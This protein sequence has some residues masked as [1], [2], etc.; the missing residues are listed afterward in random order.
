MSKP[1]LPTLFNPLEC[2]PDSYQGWYQ[3]GNGLWE[4]GRF[5][6]ALMSFD[7][8]IDYYPEDY[9]AWYKRGMTLEQLGRFTEA[10]ESYERAARIQ[11]N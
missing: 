1:S 4:Q 2:R 3:Q 10:A 5:A 6:E 11:P 8:A 7:R 9:W